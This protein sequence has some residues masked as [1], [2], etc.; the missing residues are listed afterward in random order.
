MMDYPSLFAPGRIGAVDLPNRLVH[1]PMGMRMAVDG[2][3][4]D[5]DV[6]YHAERAAGGV[7]LVIVGGTLAHFTTVY[8]GRVNVEAYDPGTVEGMARRAEAIKRG[9]ARTFVQL[10]HFGRDMHGQADYASV[11]PSAVA[12][13]RD[14]VVPRE[15][16][17]DEIRMLIA[18]YVR[19]SQNVQAAGYDGV[20][21]QGANGYLVAQFLSAASN[22]RS[23]GYGGDLA[24]GRIRF[25]VE[26]LEEVRSRCGEHFALG[27]RLSAVEDDPGGLRIEDTVRVSERLQELG[28]AD[29][30]SLT[31]GMRSSYVKDGAFEEG[32]ALGYAATVKRAVDLPVIAS[33][34]IRTPEAAEAA[35]E[36][37]QADFVGLARALIAD[38]RWPV[39]AREGRAGEIRPCVGFVQDCRLS[40]GGVTCAVNARVGRESDWG[41]GPARAA[42]PERVVVV[43]GGPGGLEAARLA[44]ESGRSV[45]LFERDDEFG[46]QLRIAARGPTREDLLDLVRYQEREVRRLGVEVLLG[47][48]ATVD[49]ILERR[50]GAVVVAAGAVPA[51]PDFTVTGDAD[52][53]T[54]RDLLGG[55]RSARGRRAVVVDDGTGFWHGVSAAEY[56]AGQSHEVHLVTPARAVGLAIPH[57]SVA[58]VHE[59]LRGSGVAFRPMTAVT[60]VSAGLVTTRDTVTGEQSVIEA[61]TVVVVPVLAPADDLVR[62]LKGK[63]PALVAVG[64]CSS[65]RRLTHAILDANLAV[66]RLST[67]DL[68]PAALPLS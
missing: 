16:S 5:R 9:G 54:V 67:G 27:V 10:N 63:V 42:A 60:A 25:L 29:Y 11:A 4:T 32:F 41:T 21:I 66:L 22:Q 31:V 2:K 68:T 30:V 36:R 19:A 52:L 46:G 39:K 26:I 23:D 59:R 12:S 65:P 24:T 56:L 40:L 55:T 35:L 7:G 57:E 13:P 18:S 58:G 49:G 48:T 1:L 6:A 34:R 33:G 50:P 44:A 17:A 64:D 3:V 62:A 37:G 51:G 8:R 20:G 45:V 53:M 38:P 47:T 43:G 15:A 28:V 61:D 14:R